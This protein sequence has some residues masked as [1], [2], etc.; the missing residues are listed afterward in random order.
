MPDAPTAL[1]HVRHLAG[2]IG[3][4][5]TTTPGERAGAAYAAA[6]LEALALTATVEPFPAPVS[7]WRPFALASAAALVAT[8]LAV[9]GGR[10]GAA[11][12]AMLLAV[13]TASVFLEMYFRPNPLRALVR[14]G[15]SA[16]V[17]ATIAPTDAVTRRLV[18]AA[19]VDTHR[20]PWA[21]TTPG[22]L[23]LFKASTSAGVAAFVLGTLA[24][25]AVALLGPGGARAWLLLLAP[26]YAW[27]LGLTLQ[28]DTTPHTVGANDNASGVGVVLDIAARLRRRPL[29]RTEVT[30]LVT[31]AEEVGSYGAQA[32]VA[33]HREA[34]RGARAISVDNVAGPGAGPCWTTVEGMVFPLRPDPDLRARALALASERPELGAYERPY[35]TLHTDATAFMAAG[36]PSLSFVGLTPD[37]VIPDWHTVHD[38]LERIDPDVLAR[39]TDLVEALVRRVD[40]A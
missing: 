8:A 4:R 39:T 37:G 22:R 28:P 24:F 9:W 16:N 40:A 31:G 6:Q 7:G 30:V 1:D 14:R 17:H 21:F 26:V 11:A 29:A 25:A 27:V 13:A 38:V 12:G 2:T 5:G 23:A 35:T 18:L 33:R 20:T 34:L 19:H 36:V 3:P 32:F 15:E 10:G